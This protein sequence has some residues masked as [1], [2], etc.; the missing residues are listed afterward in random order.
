MQAGDYSF[1]LQR[2]LLTILVSLLSLP[3]LAK[4]LISER[5]QLI[6]PTAQMTIQDVASADL[7]RAPKVLSLGYTSQ[8]LWLRLRIEDSGNRPMMLRIRPALLDDVQLWV[9]DTRAVDGWSMRSTGDHHPF[10]SSERSFGTLGFLLHPTDKN[11][12]YWLRIVTTSAQ[13][14][15]VEALLLAES[16]LN[17]ARWMLLHLLNSSILFASL[18]WTVYIWRVDRLTLAGWFSAYQVSNLVYMM[19][20]M[21]FIAAF[22]PQGY[23]GLIDQITGI[24][25]IS[26]H[27]LGLL[28]NRQLLQAYGARPWMLH[29]FSAFAFLIILVL[30]VYLLG[31]PRWALS[32]NITLIA[33]TTLTTVVMCFT[34]KNQSDLLPSIGLLRKL[35]LTLL[36]FLFLWILALKGWIQVSELILHVNLLNG[37][38]VPIVTL[39]F[40]RHHVRLHRAIKNS[41]DQEMQRVLTVLETERKTV[42]ESRRFIEM[43]VHEIKT[44]L[45]IAMIGLGAL[46]S[47]SGYVT[48]IDRALNDINAVVDL[49]RLSD[50]AENSRIEPIFSISSVQGTLQ[51]C[52]ESSISP[53]RLRVVVGNGP[54]VLTDS[55]FL[56]VIISNILNNALKYSPEESIVDVSLET[57]SKKMVLTV[58]NA[59]GA[60]GLPDAQC[61]FNKYYRSPGARAKSG[62][63]LGL[64]LSLQLTRLLGAELQY[65]PRDGH[66]EFSL[67]IPV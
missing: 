52:I 39:Y 63:G 47:N 36:V 12:F 11:Q 7:A 42:L 61:L 30:V 26:T 57:Q 32:S 65:K 40:L 3:A 60:V 9:A 50:L 2:F 45:G 55:A 56:G 51:E 24:F 37:L 8:A 10:M 15:H 1:L 31:A 49:A 54:D 13:M 34:L 29:I 28:F 18:V 59:V 19:F 27:I 64:Y 23:A 46:K 58:V 14:L 5:M 16:Q 43:L 20:V 38:F 48:R 22:E 25:V 66:V 33:I 35:K 6:D 53:S 44:P 62:S 21:G 41:K 17:D 67:C 4:D